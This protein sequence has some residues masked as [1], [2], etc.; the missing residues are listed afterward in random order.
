MTRQMTSHV[1]TRWYRAPELILLQRYT[2]AIEYTRGLEPLS[3]FAQLL[4]V[5]AH[6][7]TL[8]PASHPELSPRPLTLTHPDLSARPLTPRSC[9]SFA[10]IL[11]ELLTM[12]P[13]AKFGPS[14][15]N[16]LFPGRSCFPL[17]PN[18]DDFSSPASLDQL[19]V[20]FS[21]IGTP[22]GSL[23]WIERP[24]VGD[25]PGADPNHGPGPDPNPGP[26]P[27]CGST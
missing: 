7:P 23:N 27:T 19:N 20:I 12:L 14:D 13:E 15:R 11:A 5:R 25:G 16:A 21:V 22:S 3:P 9:W 1:V 4:A 10:C 18:D 6:P 8:S 26:G 17:S 2:T 24:E